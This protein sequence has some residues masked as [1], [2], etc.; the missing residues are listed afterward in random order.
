[1]K[2]GEGVGA[3]AAC[4]MREHMGPSGDGYGTG[5]G[6]CA[7]APPVCGKAGFG[8]HSSVSRDNLGALGVQSVT[9]HPGPVS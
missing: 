8:F 9:S 6:P 3:M 5:T 7:Y 4:V 1:M 2:W